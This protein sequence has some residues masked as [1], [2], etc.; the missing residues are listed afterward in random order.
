MPPRELRTAPSD[1]GHLAYVWE[2]I[3]GEDSTIVQVC[4]NTA[5]CY[6]WIIKTGTSDLIAYQATK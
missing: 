1:N 4:M 5:E 2:D 6:A 3:P